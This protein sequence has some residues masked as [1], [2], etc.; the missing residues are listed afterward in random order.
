MYQP[1]KVALLT[2]VALIPLAVDGVQPPGL[3]AADAAPGGADA[4]QRELEDGRKMYMEGVLPSGEAMMGLVAG[5][6]PLSGQQVI[7]GWCHRRSGMGSTEGQEVVPPVTGDILYEA[8]RLP[9]SK[10]PLAPAL[11]PAYTDASL[12]RAIRDGV[13]PDGTAFSPLMPRY[14]LDDGQIEALIAYLKTLTTDPDPGVDER[15]IH[16]ATIVSDAVDMETRDAFL[17]VFEAF[18]EQKNTETRHET[19]RAEHAPWHKEWVFGPYRKW[20]LHVWE[21]KGERTSWAQQLDALYEQQ[22]VFAVLS[23]ILP[24]S[25]QPIHAFC[26]SSRL[27]CLFPITDLPV[28]AETDFYTVYFSPG[29]ILE[30]DAIV[31]HIV[32]EGLLSVPVLQVYR[33]DEPRA[34][35]AAARLRKQLTGMGA[36][37]TDFAV[38]GPGAVTDELWRALTDEH[39]AGTR[40]LW[41]ERPD[42][43]AIWQR[44]HGGDE[45]RLYLSNTLFAESFSDIRAGVRA[46]LFIVR[47]N[48]LPK[49]LPR[50]LARSTGWLKAKRIY[51]PDARRVQADAFFALKTVGGALKQIQGYFL[52]DYLLEQIEH[53]TESAT[54]TSVYPRLNLAPGQRFVSRSAYIVKLAPEGPGELI[55]VT[56]W[57]VPSFSR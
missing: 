27:P 10:P 5:D 7:C 11:R 21:L 19:F 9:T 25:W 30:A 26:E 45:G 55:P 48:E 41:L 56:R 16:F 20:V 1:I 17:D 4:Q 8:L 14:P 31:G 54:Y 24:G 51:N 42:L 37:V 52:R 57:F 29:M 22:P 47:T 38:S 44:E 2:L 39:P 43:D 36:E 3:S 32:D 49:K 46:R 35:A 18:F 53:M 23:G 40:V 13:G 6:I 12:K 15:E 50:L 34:A 28:I 33:L